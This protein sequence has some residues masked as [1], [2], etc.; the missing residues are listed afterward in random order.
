MTGPRKILLAVLS[1]LSVLLLAGF[2]FVLFAQP[3]PEPVELTGAGAIE[4]GVADLPEVQPAG[5]GEQPARSQPEPGVEQAELRVYVAGA[6]RRPGVY[7]LRAGE[8]LVDALESAGGP[9]E[10]ADL[11]AVNL[12]L[13][14]KDEGYYFIPTRGAGTAQFPAAADPA[15]GEMP[16][17]RDGG[18][19][20]SSTG[21]Q[22]TED[23]GLVNLNTATQAELEGLP[24]I[25]AARAAAIVHYREQNG[26]Y[27]AVEEIT[28]VSGIGQ[29]T[30]DG[31]EGLVTV[32]DEP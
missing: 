15:M 13:R 31:L 1:V 30:L 12:A 18:G 26:P 25:G 23:G 24:N 21:S 20:G 14:V 29:S 19:N 16:T 10:G 5:A 11:E 17:D 2:F 32:G 3:G 9:A 22:P 27:R 4:A 6:V 8:R 28:A 7:S